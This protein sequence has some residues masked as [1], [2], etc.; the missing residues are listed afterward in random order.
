MGGRV[1]E[2]HRWPCFVGYSLIKQG[3]SHLVAT[4]DRH[5]SEAFWAADQFGSIVLNGVDTGVSLPDGNWDGG[6]NPNLNS[7][8]ITAGPPRQ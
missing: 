7:L 4:S 3:Q 1:Q 6:A 5:S 2:D 8:V